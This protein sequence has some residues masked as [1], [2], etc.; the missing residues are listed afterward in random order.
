[1]GKRNELLSTKFAA[2]LRRTRERRGLTYTA[3]AANLGVHRQSWVKWETG[4]RV[5]HINAIH[6]IATSLGCSVA[7]LLR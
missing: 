2:N 5:P 3:A 4:E 6:E 7:S 1:M